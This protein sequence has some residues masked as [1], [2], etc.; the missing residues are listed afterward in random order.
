VGFNG[1]AAVGPFMFEM[2]GDFDAGRD[3]LEGEQ[4]LSVVDVIARVQMRFG[5]AAETFRFHNAMTDKKSCPGTGVDRQGLLDAVR[6]RRDELA[7]QRHAPRGAGERWAEAD[8]L[9]Q[10]RRT[11]TVLL[12]LA[13]TASRD[14][15]G[16][17]GEPLE[18]D[19]TDQQMRRIAGL[20]DI[21][22]MTP[23]RGDRQGRGGELTPD[24]L[25][26][27][28]PH[29]IN[30]TQG[31]FSST[32]LFQ[33][34][35]A[36]VDAIFDDYAERAWEV[37]KASHQP[38]RLLL[39]AHGGLISEASGLRIAHQQVA[40]W[41]RND[42][43]PIHFVWE[44]GFCDALKQILAGARS[45]M[46][47][48]AA[49]DLWD[50][51]TD[52]LVEGSARVLGGG[53][54]WLAMKR[55]AELAADDA[56]GATYVARKLQ[57]FCARHPG[58]VELHAVGHSA[59]SI[60]H[61]HF[62]PRALELGVPAFAT[63]QLLA[64]AIR[65]DEF[66]HR[67]GGLIGADV[68]HLTMYTMRRDWEEDDN[69]AG[70]YR[71]SLLY[72]ISHALEPEARAS[73]LGLEAS[74]RSDDALRA[75][76][77]LRGAA[78]ARAEVV[79]SVTEDATGPSASTSRSHGGFDNDR[80]TMNSV[81]RRILGGGHAIVDFPEEAMERAVEMWADVPAMPAEA[82][83]FVANGDAGPPAVA[84]PSIA[85]PLYVAAPAV[86]TGPPS[87]SANG[88]GGH[89]RAL[90]VGI[91]RYPTMPL[92][93][94][95]ADARMWASALQGLGF[96]APTLLVDEAATRSAILSGLER[97]IGASAPG[98][99]VVF[100]F[101][102]HGTT[103]PDMDGDEQDGD[104]PDQDEALC[105]YDIASGAYLIDDDVHGVFAAIP[106]GVNAT[107]FID[108]CHSGSITRFAVGL[109]PPSRGAQGGT[110]RAR[111]LKADAAMI[112]KHRSFRRD[113]GQRGATVPR[114]PDLMREVVFSACLSSEVAYENDGHGDFTVRA[115]RLLQ[116]GVEG[117]THEDFQRRVTDAFGPTPGQHPYLDCSP[118]ARSRGLLQPVARGSAVAGRG[119]GSKNG[120]LAEVARGLRTL[121]DLIATRS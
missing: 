36:D 31:R 59:G 88:A 33:T 37:A 105:P 87:T 34:S 102:G 21:S 17:D 106:D 121:A 120:D 45:M 40:W 41:K 6:R 115:T 93:G 61:A 66:T 75:L 90:C 92:A 51:T 114:G 2:I 97:V 100:Q 85:H 14:G 82:A 47:R 12:S 109:T 98:D 23:G 46:P 77:G 60:F 65:V 96:D 94:C 26:D 32:G 16:P 83:L 53:K 58:E 11:S 79:W 76:F 107:A 116:G 35:E 20:G 29:V 69:V 117:L 84:H 4:R 119:V 56:G 113:L 67:L 73:I 62:V 57:K 64:P 95:V 24:M 43:Y 15:A 10:R 103:L 81:A 9:A 38:V 49:R 7:A 72:L 108:C 13:G 89:R 25:I 63:L 22:R 44:T 74:V 50:H 80:P 39:W 19:M 18:S 55:S 101:A 5:L 3:R 52:P 78:S 99:V 42:I 111:F 118:A 86:I 48:A 8:R 70:L 112:A 110:R 68:R 54:I 1:N 71:K 91:D 27:L 104:T 28:R 30:L